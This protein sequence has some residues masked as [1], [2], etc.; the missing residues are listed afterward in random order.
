M[1]IWNNRRLGH[2]VIAPKKGVARETE[3]KTPGQESIGRKETFI[4]KRGLVTRFDLTMNLKTG[5]YF[6]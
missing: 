5:I 4:Q 2:T 1:T 6:E 3:R